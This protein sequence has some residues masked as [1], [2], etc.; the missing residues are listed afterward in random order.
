[1]TPAREEFEKWFCKRNFLTQYPKKE[2]RQKGFEGVPS[3]IERDGER[4]WEIWEAGWGARD[5]RR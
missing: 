3:M 4:Q 1:M 2:H 5:G